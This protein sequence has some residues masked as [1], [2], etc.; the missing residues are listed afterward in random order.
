MVF[1]FYS[2]F[3]DRINAN[4]LKSNKFHKICHDANINLPTTSLDL[5]F[6]KEN[7]NRAN[8]NFDTFLGKFNLLNLL[9]IYKFMVKILL[10]LI[11]L[12]NCLSF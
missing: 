5:I 10:S 3:G 4:N 11:N 8:M 9:Q 7:K 6:C 12:I 2:S 1:S